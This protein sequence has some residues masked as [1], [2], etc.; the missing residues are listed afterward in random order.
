MACL[1]R[2]TRNIEN[3]GL[4]DWGNGLL[5]VELN[6]N[7][8]DF[9]SVVGRRPRM[10]SAAVGRRKLSKSPIDTAAQNTPSCRREQFLFA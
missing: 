3:G 9:W 10:T 8:A 6:V 1:E 5:M 2:K 7:N 4:G